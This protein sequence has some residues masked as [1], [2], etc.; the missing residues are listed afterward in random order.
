MPHPELPYSE[1]AFANPAFAEPAFAEPAFAEPTFADPDP[2]DAWN[3]PPSQA[4]RRP[5]PRPARSRTPAAVGWV[6]AHGGAGAST[7]AKALGGVDIGDRWPEPSR[8]EPGRILVVGRTNAEGL[9]SVAQALNALRE[10]RAPGGLDLLSLVLVADAPGRLPF[11]LA[12]RVRV[13][14]S[15]APVHRVPWIPALRV[16]GR[17]KDL[18]DQL[19]DLAALVG[20]H[21]DNDREGE[22]R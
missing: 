6:K 2:A 16:G 8:G 17:P 3:A 4:P 21:A 13:I 10:G 11:S 1:P 7:L 15:V 9:Q 5:R 20:H 22:S 18:A 19:A 12:R 14:G